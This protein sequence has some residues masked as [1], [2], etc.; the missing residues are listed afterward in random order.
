VRRYSPEFRSPIPL[1]PNLAD[2][3]IEEQVRQCAYVLFSAARPVRAFLSRLVPSEQCKKGKVLTYL[4]PL[5]SDKPRLDCSC[6]LPASLI[7]KEYNVDC[8]YC[9]SQL[10]SS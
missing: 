1:R 6:R 5:G 4:G 10:A 3:E 7:Y 9:V 2:A 8:Y